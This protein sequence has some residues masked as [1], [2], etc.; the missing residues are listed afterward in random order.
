MVSEIRIPTYPN[1]ARYLS[2]PT[3]R[4]DTEYYEATGRLPDPKW[5]GLTAS[6]PKDIRPNIRLD[7]EHHLIQDGVRQFD[8]KTKGNLQEIEEK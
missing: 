4:S 1:L 3:D 6:S 5:E 7:T 2:Q 8:P